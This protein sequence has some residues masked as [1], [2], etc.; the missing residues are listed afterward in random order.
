MVA[1]REVPNAEETMSEDEGMTKYAVVTDDPKEKTAS[2]GEDVTQVCP[3][4]AKKLDS[5]GACPT[6]GTE[7]FESNE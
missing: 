7:P 6:H 4:C 2:E 3:T 5:G 1:A